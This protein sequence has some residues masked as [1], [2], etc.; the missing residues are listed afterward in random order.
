MTDTCRILITGSRYWPAPEIIQAAFAR[1]QETHP[2]GQLVLVHGKCDPRAPL[3]RERVRWGKALAFTPEEQIAGLGADWLA[4]R[5]ATGLGWEIEAYPADW[6]QYGKAAGGIR[7]GEM[8]ATGPFAACLA[9]A[10]AAES[11]QGTIDCAAKASVA[12][13]ATLFYCDMCTG[14]SLHPCHSH[15]L[16]SVITAWGAASRRSRRKAA[17]QEVLDFGLT[18]PG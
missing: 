3:T 11:N 13:I 15:S 1:L 12:G 4:D 2:G 5:I 10:A 14:P 8:I 7:N 9:F 18:P 17:Q 6:K 16:D